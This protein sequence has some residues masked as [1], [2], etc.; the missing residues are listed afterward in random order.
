MADFALLGSLAAQLHQEFVKDY[1]ILLPVFFMLA[2]AL[3]WFR[4][5]QGSADFIDTVKRAVIATL[6]VTMFQ[7]ISD[8][9]LMVANEIASRISDM[10]GLDAVYK[11]AGEKAKSY[12]LSP[13]SLVLGFN[14]LLVSV[15]SFLSYI[16]LYIARYVTVAVYHFMWIFL[17]ILSPLLILFSLFK[18]TSHITMNLFKSLCE[19]ASWKIV[20]AIMSAML[21]ALAFGNAYAADGN[22]LTVIVLNFVIAIAMLSTPLI[23][24]SLVNTGLSQVAQTLSAGAA[25]AMASVPARGATVMS[26]GRGALNESAGFASHVG[27]KMNQALGSQ[28]SDIARHT[29]YQPN[30]S[31]Q[32]QQPPPSVP[33]SPK[34]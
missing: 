3:D 25:L 26:A 30:D 8:A 20:W 7:E 18:G 14:D 12:T 33:P 1:Y 15:I 32:G 31:N 34:T 27:N 13:T 5:P 16:I 21:T 9:I 2:I 4:H 29:T 24:K 17:S 28:P 6:L 11:M 23:V 19:V 10:S 22:Y